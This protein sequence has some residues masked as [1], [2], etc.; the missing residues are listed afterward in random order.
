MLEL[1]TNSVQLSSTG[2]TLATAFIRRLSMSEMRETF[3]GTKESHISAYIH[4][5]AVYPRNSRE[6]SG[7]TKI[8]GQ[9]VPA[10]HVSPI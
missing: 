6:S 9:F 8:L 3:A 7:K 10:S 2:I 5:L 4:T 1:F